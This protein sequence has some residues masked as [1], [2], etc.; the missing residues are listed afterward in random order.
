M[1]IVSFSIVLLL[2]LLLNHNILPFTSLIILELKVDL[3]NSTRWVKIDPEIAVI[4]DSFNWVIRRILNS[5]FAAGCWLNEESLLDLSVTLLK[6]NPAV[7]SRVPVLIISLKI[8]CIIIYSD[9]SKALLFFCVE[10]ILGHFVVKLRVMRNF[11]GNLEIINRSDE[12]RFLWGHVFLIFIDFRV[13][14]VIVVCHLDWEW[15]LHE[16]FVLGS[17]FSWSGSIYDIGIV[18]ATNQEGAESN[19]KIKTV[20]SLPVENVCRWRNDLG[21]LISILKLLILKE[22]RDE[23]WAL[24][25]VVELSIRK[26]SGS[27]SRADKLADA[28]FILRSK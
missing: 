13:F 3:I 11:L 8:R 16:S 18:A 1:F 17:N 7:Q 21:E 28:A 19:S 10:L 24:V 26:L 25:P 22:I 6:K 27:E 14:L 12:R 20:T 4:E 5:I 15:T 9:C 23:F 2:I